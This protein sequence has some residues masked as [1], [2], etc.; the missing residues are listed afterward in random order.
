MTKTFKQVLSAKR[1]LQVLQTHAAKLREFGVKK[2]GL[3][4]SFSTGKASKKSD[5]DFLVSF[6]RPSFDNF[7]EA[8]FFLEKLFNRK[9]DLVTEESLKPGLRFIKKEALYA[10]AV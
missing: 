8:K 5:L 9:V 2:I 1:I 4:G 6:E 7:M 10:K 3:F